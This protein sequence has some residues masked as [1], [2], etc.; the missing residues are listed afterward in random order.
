MAESHQK[1]NCAGGVL[2]VAEPEQYCERAGRDERE[3]IASDKAVAI[4]SQHEIRTARYA[5][6]GDNEGHVN[7]AD[8]RRNIT[9]HFRMDAGKWARE[10][11]V[12]DDG[13][14]I[15]ASQEDHAV[16]WNTATGKE[17]GRVPEHV[18][19]F[20]RDQKHFI[21]Q[22]RHDK[23]SIYEYAGFKRIA[24]LPYMGGG[25]S[26]FLFSPDDQYCAI[27]FQS[28]YPA[29]E[30]TYPFVKARSNNV[31]VR[32]YCLDPFSEV[33]NF[34][35]LNI[36]RI[37]TFAADSSAYLGNE[38]LYIKRDRIEGPWR[39]DLKTF[40]VEAVRAA[41]KQQPTQTLREI[42]LSENK[43]PKR[44]QNLRSFRLFVLHF[45]ALKPDSR[46]LFL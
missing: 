23:I 9:N 12:L 36:S 27:E 38:T 8:F 14:T 20:S 3:K 17:I 10:I 28:A 30:E 15:A 32:L 5:V 43:Q 39:F 31:Q 37:G 33:L 46:A 26:V 45:I 7:F 44:T 1:W 22:N 18:Y 19:C 34:P 21:A 29:P 24:Q 40:K 13:K 16:F 2:S 35:V 4:A 6:S 25:V 11:F 42:L 41:K